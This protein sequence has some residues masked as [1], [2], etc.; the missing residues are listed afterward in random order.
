MYR[1]V[2]LPPR[3]FITIPTGRTLRVR[4]LPDG[5]LFSYD[6]HVWEKFSDADI[7]LSEFDD[8][9][10]TVPWSVVENLEVIEL[11]RLEP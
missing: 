7:C 10:G 1:I 8:E 3:Q 4:D 6:G 2:K 9:S 11:V 5:S